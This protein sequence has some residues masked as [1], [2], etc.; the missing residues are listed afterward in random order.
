MQDSATGVVEEAAGRRAA[1]GGGG[2]LEKDEEGLVGE[3]AGAAEVQ[4]RE[5]AP[6]G[7]GGGHGGQAVVAEL[8]RVAEGEAREAAE[9]GHHGAQGGVRD[10]DARQVEGLEGREDLEQELPPLPLGLGPEL[11]G[12]RPQGLRPRAAAGAPERA[13]PGKKPPDRAVVPPAV[14]AEMVE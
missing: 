12:V 4:G 9:R 7:E 10:G 11:G 14:S 8:G 1:G 13:V 6:P 3:L 5:A 2:H